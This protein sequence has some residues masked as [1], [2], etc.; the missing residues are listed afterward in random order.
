MLE[1][2]R[3]A[4]GLGFLLATIVFGTLAYLLYG[5][6]LSDALF[7]V[8]ISVSTVG[9]GEIKPVNTSGLRLVTSLV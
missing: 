2:Q 3:I 5:W 9:Y 4:W 7:M 6:S 1:L 8:I